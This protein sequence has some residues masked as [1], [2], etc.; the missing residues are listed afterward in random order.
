MRPPWLGGGVRPLPHAAAGL[1]HSRGP[2][3]PSA[4]TAHPPLALKSTI[5]KAAL[6]IADMDRGLYADHLLTRTAGLR[7]SI[8]DGHAGVTA[9]ALEAF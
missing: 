1:W 4:V 9:M 6:Q 2:A 3:C 8:V 5:Y 7:E